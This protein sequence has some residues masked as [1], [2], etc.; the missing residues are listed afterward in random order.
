[1]RQSKRGWLG[2]LMAVCAHLWRFCT[3]AGVATQLGMM[4]DADEPKAEPKT[5]APK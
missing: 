1:M 5:G 2:A 3:S 4:P